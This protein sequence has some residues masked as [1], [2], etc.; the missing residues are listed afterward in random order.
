MK[1]NIP[2]HFSI[3]FLLLVFLLSQN[4]FAQLTGTKTI[5]GDY[6]TIEAAI[7]DL[8]TQGVGSGGVTFDVAANHT[9]TFTSDSAGHIT[10]TGTASDPIV[11]QISGVGSNPLI[12]ASGLGTIAS[13]TT[14]GNNGD[15]II[16]I[17]G[18]D[19]ITF[20]AI[21]LQENVAATG[22]QFS[23]YGY[24][25]KKA[26]S[27]DACKNVTIKNCNITLDKAT[28]YS[29]GIY[30]S[31]KI[32][33]ADANLTSIGGSTEN[34]KVFNNSISDCYGAIQIRGDSQTSPYAWY[35]QNIEIGVDGGNTIT[36]FGGGTSSC[37]P[38]YAIYQNGLKV[39]NNNISGGAG[40]TS[41]L[42]GIY[43]STGNNSDVDVY[44]NTITLT[45]DATTSGFYA[46]YVSMG[47]TGTTNTVNIYDNTIENCTRPAVT[48]GTMY[49]LYRSSSA[50]NTNIYGNTI[51]NNSKAVQ[52]LVMDCILRWWCRWH[53]TVFTTTIFIT[54]PT[55]RDYV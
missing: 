25:L 52:V 2:K 29:Y 19:Y 27:D 20:D 16:F 37:Y 26:S 8:H 11:F 50:F 13:S 48:S 55:H 12:T 21:D 44:N 5:P 17:E 31:N 6:A 38:I 43:L 40:Q 33:T 36:N 47:G 49:M 41:T 28:K 22:V 45:S 53:R 39:A 51:R 30:I 4:T 32:H 34:V 42:Y 54:I 15:G 35:D 1:K 46:L 18:G 9:E 14:N 7:A 24:Y 23:E 10:A 3:V